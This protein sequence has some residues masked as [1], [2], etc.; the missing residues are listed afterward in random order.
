MTMASF[1]LISRGGASTSGAEKPSEEE[2]DEEEEEE[3][4]IRFWRRRP[5]L[6]EG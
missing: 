4:P 5:G 2:E 1:P 3:S 6:L